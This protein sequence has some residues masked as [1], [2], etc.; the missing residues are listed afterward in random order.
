[1]PY[2]DGSNK[3]TDR[4]WVQKLDKYLSLR[5]MP[6]EDAIRFS[7]L[8]LEGAAH[9][10]WYHGLVTLGHNLITTYEDFTNRVIERFDVK[11]LEVSFY[12]LAQ[13]K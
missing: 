1:M 8:H 7:T 9:E 6:K 10:L 12:E 4:S 3:C 13:L 11:D 2:Y 5:P